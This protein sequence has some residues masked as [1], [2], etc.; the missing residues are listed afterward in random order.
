MVSNPLKSVSVSH[1]LSGRVYEA[2]HTQGANNRKQHTPEDSQD[3]SLRDKGS[4][5]SEMDWP[6][7]GSYD[8][9]LD[10]RPYFSDLENNLLV[11][12]TKTPRPTERKKRRSSRH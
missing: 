1:S 6:P 8:G 9:S 11:S 4:Q 7:R 3:I 12:R 10:T 2:K 5:D